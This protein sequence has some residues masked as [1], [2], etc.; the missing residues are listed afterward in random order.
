[1][2]FSTAILL[3]FIEE[4]L[5]K[6]FFMIIMIIIFFL[7]NQNGGNQTLIYNSRY[8]SVY[9]INR[10]IYTKKILRCGL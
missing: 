9:F 5:V 1:M 8:S 7:T 4:H 6:W 10:L 3:E 2:F